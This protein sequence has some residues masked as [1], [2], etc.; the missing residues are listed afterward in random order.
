VNL[1]AAVGDTEAKLGA[2][3]LCH[4]AFVPG[5][6]AGIGPRRELIHE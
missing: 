5:G 3:D 2:G 6:D 4:I 1:H